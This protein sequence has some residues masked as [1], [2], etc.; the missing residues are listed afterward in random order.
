VGVHGWKSLRG[1]R[2]RITW[3]P[4]FFWSRVSML[5]QPLTL[6]QPKLAYALLCVKDL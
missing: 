2:A 5:S 6:K 4:G 1:E 3:R